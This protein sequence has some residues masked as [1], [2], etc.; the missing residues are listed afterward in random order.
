MALGAVKSIPDKIEA[1]RMATLAAFYQHGSDKEA[2]RTLCM[3]YLQHLLSLPAV[4]ATFKSRKSSCLTSRMK[5]RF[6][7]V[8]RDIDDVLYELNAFAWDV[9]CYLQE[10]GKGVRWPCLMA[11]SFYM[12]PLLPPDI[13]D[14]CSGKPTCPPVPARY[15][16]ETSDKH[17]SI[18]VRKLETGKTYR[19]IQ[20]EANASIITTSRYLVSFKLDKQGDKVKVKGKGK[21]KT[22]VKDTVTSV[23]YV[24]VRT[25]SDLSLVATLDFSPDTPTCGDISACARGDKMAVAVGGMVGLWDVGKGAR[26]KCHWVL[27][28]PEEAG[29]VKGMSWCC[30]RH[31]DVRIAKDDTSL[32]FWAE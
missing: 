4:Q 25:E 20:T 13:D 22:P 5:R 8:V 19:H 30:D 23:Q 3:G 11:G 31:V 10:E 27:K 12:H 17:V 14:P 26:G 7:K 21:G 24:E 32:S 9:A 2:A 28:L 15:R 29:G 6:K 16:Y 18:K 1:V